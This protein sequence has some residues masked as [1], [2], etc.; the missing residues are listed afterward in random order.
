MNLPLHAFLLHRTTCSE[1]PSQHFPSLDDSGFEQT[2]RRL[3]RPP[4]Q[5]LVHDPQLPQVD[6]ELSI[7]NVKR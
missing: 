1:L 3:L 5:L 6:Q 7:Q 2:R 4:P